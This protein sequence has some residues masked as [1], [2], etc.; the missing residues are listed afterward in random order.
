M[1]KIIQKILSF[2]NRWSNNKKPKDS[3]EQEELKIK[4]LLTIE[5]R[6]EI[7]GY[8]E[9]W[10]AS[11]TSAAERGESIEETY[12]ELKGFEALM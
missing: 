9:H 8:P 1:K 3:K 11:L 6:F 4:T 12:E 10:R 7:L 2:K 5:Q